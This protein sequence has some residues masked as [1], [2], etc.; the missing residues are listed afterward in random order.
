MLIGQSPQIVK[1]RKM[2]REVAHTDENVL[3]IGEAG[4]GKKHVAQ[5]IHRRSKQKSK[6]FV[7]LNASAIGDTITETNLYGETNEGPRGVERKIGLLEQAKRGILY[8]ETVEEMA[9]EFQQQFFN[10]LKERKFQK[11]REKDFIE[12]DF[13]VFAATTDHLSEQVN[14]GTF[15]KDLFNLLNT[16][17]IHV[18]PLNERKQ[19]IPYL[20]THFLEAYCQEFQQETPPI[21]PDLF[22]SLM[23]YK[24]PG[25]VF[26]LK[27]CV[28]NLI[29]MSPQGELSLEY[30]PFEIKKHPFEF[31]ENRH[32]PDA[33]AEV[34]KYLIKKALSK[35]AGN[36]TKAAHAL[37]VSEAALRYK[38]KK[39][40]FLRKRAKP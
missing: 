17:V 40:G 6:P 32:L 37:D 31:L 36:Q 26:E 35:F 14:N 4:T 38:M 8:L 9:P 39:Y 15:R 34:E 27:N 11:P 22:E 10:I 19:D 16:F 23:E 24:W 30:L 29:L 1:A 28:R 20:F 3:I 18:P 7:V 33:M 5:E 13:R 21:P 12:A 2:I 25:N